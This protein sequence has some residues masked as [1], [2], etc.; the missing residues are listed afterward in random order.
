M[1]L[2]NRVP[3][4][5][6]VHAENEIVPARADENR[7]PVLDALR[8]YLHESDSSELLRRALRVEYLSAVWREEFSQN[9]SSLQYKIIRPG[10]A[11]ANGAC[12][13]VCSAIA[14]TLNIDDYNLLP[15]CVRAEPKAF[16]CGGQ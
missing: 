8:L 9:I 14:R 6:E 12:Y 4:E 1:P 3:R 10:Y 5:G 15:G 11:V 7:V 16:H 13:G 2:C